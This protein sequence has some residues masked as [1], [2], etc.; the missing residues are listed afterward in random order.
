MKKFILALSLL[1]FAHTAS[2]TV[3]DF[4]TMAEGSVS[5]IGDAT[6]TLAGPGESGDPFVHHVAGGGLWN[7]TDGAAY[8]TNE[9][10]RVVF[11]APVAGVGFEYNAQGINGDPDQGWYAY[12]A[13]SVL[14]ASG[15][16]TGSL[17][18]YDLS[19]YTGISRIDWH[20]GRNDWL[21]NLNVLTYTAVPGPASLGL[22]AFGLVAFSTLRRRRTQ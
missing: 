22:F 2:A 14:I 18:A 16:F 19:A 9:I 15:S 13:A 3:L 8:P 11:D 6:F 1:C 20:N 12:N 17:S 5:T 4:T 21:S 7:S 10:L